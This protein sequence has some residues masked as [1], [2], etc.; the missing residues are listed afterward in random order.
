[1]NNIKSG[2]ALANGI[3]IFYKYYVNK[4]KQAPALIMMRG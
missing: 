3:N 2:K 1:M 4:N